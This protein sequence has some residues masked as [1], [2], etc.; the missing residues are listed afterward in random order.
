MCAWASLG[1][2]LCLKYQIG[3]SSAQ[4]REGCWAAPQGSLGT[5]GGTC[6]PWHF[7]A[8]FTCTEGAQSPEAP[9]SWELRVLVEHK[10]PRVGGGLAASWSGNRA[11]D[12][13]DGKALNSL[14]IQRPFKAEAIFPSSGAAE[15]CRGCSA[16]PPLSFVLLLPSPSPGALVVRSRNNPKEQEEPLARLS[17]TGGVVGVSLQG[18]ELGIP[19][20]WSSTSHPLDGPCG[21]FPAQ[22]IPWLCGLGKGSSRLSPVAAGAFPSLLGSAAASGAAGAAASPALGCASWNSLQSSDPTDSTSLPC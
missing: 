9:C 5:A 15:W 10:S 12:V 14:L 2:S 6:A 19:R 1:G 18:Q 16:L 13:F 4:L 11:K 8:P 17:G 22:D 21:A 20:S 3:L 7:L